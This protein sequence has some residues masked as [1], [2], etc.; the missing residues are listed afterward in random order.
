MCWAIPLLIHP[1]WD[2][3]FACTRGLAK[4]PS[5]SGR[6][7]QGCPNFLNPS[8]HSATCR[9]ADVCGFLK[10]GFRVLQSCGCQGGYRTLQPLSALGEQARSLGPWPTM[11]A[12]VVALGLILGSKTHCPSWPDANKQKAL[13]VRSYFDLSPCGQPNQLQGSLQAAK[14]PARPRLPG[15]FYSIS[16]QASGSERE[17]GH[18]SPKQCSNFH[19]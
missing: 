19:T 14:A 10:L 16:A 11:F 5:F 4:I 17:F 1:F 18:E 9:S 6:L 12:W 7:I 15:R 13:S 3:T 2:S 8:F